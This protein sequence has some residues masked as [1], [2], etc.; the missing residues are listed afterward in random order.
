MSEQT[1]HRLKVRPTTDALFE[2]VARLVNPPAVSRTETS[3]LPAY[4]QFD[5]ADGTEVDLS[6]FYAPPAD[7]SR[8]KPR[9]R[10]D[11]H[12]RTDELWVVAEGDFFLPLSA[13]RYPDDPDDPPRPEDFLCFSIKPGDLFV[14]QPNVWHCGPWPAKPDTPVRFYMLLSGHRKGGTGER[15]E[16]VDFY[17][18]DFPGNMVVV[19]DLDGL[20][21]P[22]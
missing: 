12:L 16:F 3:F 4:A 18:V 19:P 15:G 5:I 6:Y 8:P 17:Q 20:G 22:R 2:T 10:F 7:P 21:R 1:I 11:R 14:I 9:S 13:C